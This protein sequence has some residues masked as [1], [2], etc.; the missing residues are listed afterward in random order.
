M[1][2]IDG[3][4]S[5]SSNEGIIMSFIVFLGMVSFAIAFFFGVNTIESVAVT[6]VNN[7]NTVTD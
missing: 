7:I 5:Y 4:D 3:N 2:Y 1:A 6:S